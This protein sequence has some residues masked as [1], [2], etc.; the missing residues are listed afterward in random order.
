LRDDIWK[1]TDTS[2]TWHAFD[3]TLAEARAGFADISAHDLEALIEEAVAAT[4]ETP[5]S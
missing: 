1:F 4:R 3:Q 5:R 2:V